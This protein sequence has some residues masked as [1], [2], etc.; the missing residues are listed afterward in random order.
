M[1]TNKNINLKR[2]YLVI[3]FT[4][5]GTII[6]AGFASGREIVRF[7]GNYGYWSLLLIL[8]AGFLFGY[9]TY[10][11]LDLGRKRKEQNIT[12]ITKSAFGKHFA[13]VDFLMLFAYLIGIAAMLSA[14]ESLSLIIFPNF[15]SFI[16]SIIT[17]LLSIFVVVGGI[18]RLSK[19]NFILVPLIIVLMLFVC[20]RYIIISPIAE[21]DFLPAIN[22][23]TPITAIFFAMLYVFM[24]MQIVSEIMIISGKKSF[25][26]TP[27]L[28]SILG[29]LLVTIC[30]AVVICAVLI[31]GQSVFNSD[32]PIVVISLNVGN[33][34]GYIYAV[35]MWGGIF[36]TLIA[37]TLLISVWLQTKIKSKWLS[38]IIVT[39][40]GYLLSLI[41]FENIVES[42]YPI[43]GLI[44]TIYVLGI[45][46]D[47]YKT[48]KLNENIK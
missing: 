4:F 35:V 45:T 18:E 15:P 5:V 40:A 30:L 43:T 26:K 36:S 39:F 19:V 27:V 32:L 12:E 28:A 10:V 20:I 33:L 38:V 9:F 31:G 22:W 6:G 34:A 16:F 14:A 37:G 23:L 7:F 3:A 25:L 8:F 1:T 21:L 47:Y 17:G 24:N 2:D 13:L 48:K 41:G 29:A 46:V 42:F 44:G 11:M